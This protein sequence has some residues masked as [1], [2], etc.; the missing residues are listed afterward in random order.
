ML[1]NRMLFLLII[2]GGIIL[3]LFFL[4]TKI[5]ISYNSPLNT[6]PEYETIKILYWIGFILLIIPLSLEKCDKRIKIIALIIIIVFT[7][8]NYALIAPYGR[9]Y[10]KDSIYNLQN[11]ENLI[12]NKYWEKGGGT[13]YAKSYSY[14]PALAILNGTISLMTNIDLNVLFL[15]FHNFL[16]ALLIP[17]LLYIIFKGTIKKK[18]I[19]IAIFLYFTSPSLKTHIHQEGLGIL[20]LLLTIYFLNNAEKNYIN[21]FLATI[22]SLITFFS[23]HFSSYILIGWV[24]FISIPCFIKHLTKNNTKQALK[25]IIFL[26]I[27]FSSLLFI[28]TSLNRSL[29]LHSLELVNFKDWLDFEKDISLNENYIGIDLAPYEIAMVILSVFI[30]IILIIL[31]LLYKKH[32]FNVIT[33]FIYCS[34]ITLLALTF[35]PTQGL[36]I[37]L[38]IFEFSYIAFIPIIIVGIE[39]LQKNDNIKYI[40]P[41]LLIILFIGGNVLIDGGQARYLFTE[42]DKIT[43]DNF[44]LETPAIFEAGEYLKSKDGEILG[45]K[46]INNIIGGYYQFEVHV[47]KE[48]Q[49]KKIFGPSSIISYQDLNYLASQQIIYIIPNNYQPIT[50]NSYSNQISF[51]KLEYSLYLN[52]I[53][54][55]N[56]LEIFRIR[57]QEL[58]CCLGYETKDS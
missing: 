28:P 48:N 30:I 16:R 36:Y 15:Y 20:L 8:L 51:D 10:G 5:L 34:L 56:D 9:V 27:I 24:S 37:F 25:Y 12:E 2:L 1:K 52:K 26:L 6:I 40:I 43:Q 22:V 38:R 45:D 50:I 35:I 23:H 19:I 54:S 3:S 39:T 32:S 42:K 49:L 21:I 31:G 53:Y 7:T 41:F 46:L 17:L 18:Y 33:S 55:N 4:T 57:D 44:I 29:A 47:E 11:T 14:F 58:K 13:G